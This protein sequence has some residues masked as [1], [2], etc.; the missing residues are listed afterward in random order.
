MGNIDNPQVIILSESQRVSLNALKEAEDNATRNIEQ[1]QNEIAQRQAQVKAYEGVRAAVRSSKSLVFAEI[2]EGQG[3]KR[4]AT[5]DYISN[6]K[7]L[8]LI[9]D[10]LP[11]TGQ[12][13]GNAG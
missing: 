7:E 5:S 10:N 3:L 12:A 4:G 11:Q 1:L 13:Q 8:I 9:A 6:G 2:E